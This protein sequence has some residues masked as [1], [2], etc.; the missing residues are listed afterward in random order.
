[1]KLKEP[2]NEAAPDYLPALEAFMRQFVRH[3]TSIPIE[4]VAD[5]SICIEGSQLSNLSYGGICCSVDDPIDQGT[6]IK[7]RIPLLYPSYEGKGVVV[8]CRPHACGYD[9]GIQFID[10]HEAFKSR[11]VEQV[12]KIEEYRLHCETQGTLMTSEEAAI[13]WIE[14]YAADFAHCHGTSPE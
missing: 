8:W 2:R 3:P 7:I 5:T 4:L 6:T 11:M 14:K 9:L 12:C 1:M 13:E 10:K